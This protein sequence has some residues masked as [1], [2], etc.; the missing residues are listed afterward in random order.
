M[1]S[2]WI[3]RPRTE[4]QRRRVSRRSDPPILAAVRHHRALLT[5]LGFAVLADQRTRHGGRLAFALTDLVAG[6][7]DQR[8]AD[9]DAG[10]L[11][12]TV[13]MGG[14]DG[15]V[16]AF[17]R[18]LPD[19][20]APPP[21]RDS[22]P[23]PKPAP[24]QRCRSR[25]SHRGLPCSSHTCGIDEHPGPRIAYLGIQPEARRRIRPELRGFLET[26]FTPANRS[27][28]PQRRFIAG[29]EADYPSR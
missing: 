28:K 9:G 19:D 1:P 8:T 22:S 15:L 5:G 29:C 26:P 23:A 2:S 24:R 27:G 17:L 10:D 6:Q 14:G 11:L 4:P 20:R 3:R 25:A 16:P 12:V 18:R 7:P 21:R 13:L